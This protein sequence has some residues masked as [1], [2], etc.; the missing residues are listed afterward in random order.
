M[1]ATSEIVLLRAAERYGK[2]GWGLP[3]LPPPA[4]SNAKRGIPL[5]S[6]CRRGSYFHLELMFQEGPSYEAAKLYAQRFTILELDR[7][8]DPISRYPAG[9][10]LLRPVSSPLVRSDVPRRVLRWISPRTRANSPR[11]RRTDPER[12][13]RAHPLSCDRD[14]D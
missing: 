7:H 10:Y 13:R 9:H 14:V 5:H 2:A 1:R 12:A 4:A 6:A 8:D 11:D 3:G